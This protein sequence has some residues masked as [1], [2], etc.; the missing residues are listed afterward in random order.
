MKVNT[1][2]RSVA[3]QVKAAKGKAHG[4]PFQATPKFGYIF[5]ASEIVDGVSPGSYSHTI[6]VENQPIKTFPYEIK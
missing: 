4:L 5:A 3:V 2:R 1:T 6:Y